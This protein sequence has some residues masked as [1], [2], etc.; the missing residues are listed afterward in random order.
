MSKIRSWPFGGVSLAVIAIALLA[1]PAR[2]EGPVLVPISPGHALAVLDSVA[3][4]PLLV[5]AGWLYWR[6]W[7][8]RN[9]LCEVLRRSPG[10]STLG[11]F[12]AGAG[13][14]L[15]LASDLS[16][17]FW[18]WAIGAALFGAMTIAALVVATVSK[19]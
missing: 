17:F 2:I 13:L 6:V 4:G 1:A 3:L 10:W 19:E 9:R 16:Q 7:K 15:L 18:W 11:A 14:G 8:R 12:A 5:G